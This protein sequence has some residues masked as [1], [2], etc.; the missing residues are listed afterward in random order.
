[1]SKYT[2]AVFQPT[3]RPSWA[4]AFEYIPTEELAKILKAITHFPNLEVEDSVFW[5]QTIKP[6]LEQQYQSFNETC[7]KRGRGART[8]WGEHK[9]S[10][11]ITQDKLCKDKD[12]DNDKDKD[13]DENKDNKGGMGGKEKEENKAK[14]HN[15]LEICG[16]S[17]KATDAVVGV[18]DRPDGTTREGIQIKNPRLMAFVRQ[19]F[20][21]QVLNKVSDWAID[22][23]QRGHTY[24][25]TALLKLLCKFQS[26]V[27]P[28]I[29]FNHVQSEYLTF[30]FKGE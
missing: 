19:R 14:V 9:L 15:M 21:K 17:F 12:K 8:Y 2:P 5:N 24:N 25:A 13:K 23:N 1:M 3:L 18:F 26:N 29:N 22:H 27:E 11:T 28:T 4:G 7:E 6:D 16:N 20:D 30:K 10:L